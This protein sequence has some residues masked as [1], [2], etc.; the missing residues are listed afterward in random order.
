MI[1]QTLMRSRSFSFQ[2][3][4]YI[5][6]EYFRLYIIIIKRELEINKR[7]IE[8]FDNLLRTIGV[9]ELTDFFYFRTTT[10][11]S[12]K[13]RCISKFLRYADQISER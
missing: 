3:Q 11:S 8:I 5:I 13:F 2:P 7:N 10:G 9:F 1:D 12:L 6:I 4:K